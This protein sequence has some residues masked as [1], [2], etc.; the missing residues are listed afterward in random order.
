MLFSKDLNEFMGSRCEHIGSELIRSKEYRELRDRASGL[1]KAI[2]DLLGPENKKL[3]FDFEEI[4]AATMAVYEEYVYKRGIKDG[5]AL[6]QELG[7]FG[8][9][10]AKSDSAVGFENS[11]YQQSAVGRGA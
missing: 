7:L 4:A 5:A 9:V 2:A 10:A 3:I 1:L 11:A 8:V 6:V